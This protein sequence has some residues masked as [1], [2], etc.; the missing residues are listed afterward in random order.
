MTS[1]RIL[2]IATRNKSRAAMRLHQQI[3]VTVD[4]GLDGD[5]RGRRGPRQVTVLSEHAWQSAC[6]E[7]GTELSWTTRRANLL[8]D[9]LDLM[10]S[11]GA[12]LQVG[13]VTL[14]VTSEAD[15]C[16]RMNESSRGLMD[17]LTPQ[18]RGGV[19]CQVIRGGI[20]RVGDVAT[21]QA[22][23]DVQAN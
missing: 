7:L 13:D 21:V 5:F 6:R 15:P 3:D 17:A 22:S 12:I 19:C 10:H 2:G 8:V 16:Q 14:K 9:G 23:A 20:I 1:G 4:H 18:W 11:T